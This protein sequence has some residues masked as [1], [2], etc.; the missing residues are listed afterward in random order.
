VKSHEEIKKMNQM[1]VD[2]REELTSRK[3]VFSDKHDLL[4]DAH[5]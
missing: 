5:L 3:P 4:V 1:L 2:M